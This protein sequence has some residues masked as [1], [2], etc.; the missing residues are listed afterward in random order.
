[1]NVTVHAET[2][3]NELKRRHLPLLLSTP[4]ITQE[5]MNLARLPVPDPLTNARRRLAPFAASGRRRGAL[6]IDVVAGVV[7]AEPALERLVGVRPAVGRDL[8]GVVT[9]TVNSR[10]R[11]FGSSVYSERQ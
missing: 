3:V 11:P 6:P 7:A 8:V 10:S 2:S 9:S 4:A 1:M 5:F